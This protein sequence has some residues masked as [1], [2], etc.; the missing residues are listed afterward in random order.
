MPVPA[1]PD[2]ECAEM[3]QNGNLVFVD[4]A[5]LQG[6]LAVANGNTLTLNEETTLDDTTFILDTVLQVDAGGNTLTGTQTLTIESSGSSCTSSA[7][8]TWER[9]RRVAI[10]IQHRN[11]DRGVTSC[12]SRGSR[13]CRPVSWRSAVLAASMLAACGSDPT[14][15]GGGGTEEELELFPPQEY[16]DDFDSGEAGRRWDCEAFA[17]APGKS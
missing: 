8:I 7:D 6:D 12:W 10:E 5:F 14:G 4:G 9:E 3:Y 15:T 13:F 2:P 17:R 16:S 1:D 11:H